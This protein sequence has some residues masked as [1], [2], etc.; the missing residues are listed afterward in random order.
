MNSAVV[1]KVSVS[2]CENSYILLGATKRN[3]HLEELGTLYLV[4][5]RSDVSRA[6][7]NGVR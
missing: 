4:K 1:L 7:V 5:D 6:V 3:K 2:C